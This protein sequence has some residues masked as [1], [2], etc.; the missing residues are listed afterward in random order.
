MND[1]EKL[2]LVLAKLDALAQRPAGNTD[3]PVPVA[4]WP[5][6]ADISALKTGLNQ[7]GYRSIDLSDQNI[8]IMLQVTN[9]NVEKSIKFFTDDVQAQTRGKAIESASPS[10]VTTQTDRSGR[11]VA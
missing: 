8:Y 10:P 1:S 6:E 4:Y 3:L 11:V 2:D 9:G 5:N 7:L